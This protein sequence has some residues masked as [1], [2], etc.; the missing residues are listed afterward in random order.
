MTRLTW[1][2]ALSLL[3][4]SAVLP[5]RAQPELVAKIQQELEGPLTEDSKPNAGVPQGEMLQG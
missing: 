1:C 3:S 2:I 5:V 4:L